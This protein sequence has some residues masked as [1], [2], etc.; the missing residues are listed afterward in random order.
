MLDQYCSTSNNFL[1]K[2]IR[3]TKAFKIAETSSKIT[4]R[5]YILDIRDQDQFLGVFY[6]LNG[7]LSI[8]QISKKNLGPEK[9]F[10]VI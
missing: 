1:S 4:V 3:S 5:T 8:P 7:N 10:G 6:L 9:P 2:I